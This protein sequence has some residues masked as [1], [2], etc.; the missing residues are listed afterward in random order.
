MKSAR[1]SWW[2]VRL[3]WLREGTI[4]P[5]QQLLP[6]PPMLRQPRPQLLP[7]VQPPS[8]PQLLPLL[9]VLLQPRPPPQLQLL[10]TC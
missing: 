6:Q 5:R 9:Q 3:R 1:A 2:K 10:L 8:Q 7:L 4:T